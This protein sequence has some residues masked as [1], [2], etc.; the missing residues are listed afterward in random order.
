M[1]GSLVRADALEVGYGLPVCPPMTFTLDAGQ[2]LAV[3]GA[4]GTGKSTLLRTVVGLLEPHAGSLTVLG[5]VPDERSASF[6][7]DVAAD[8][9]EDAFFPS[10]TAREHLLLVA[11]GHGVDD[12]GGLA[13]EL[14]DE[15]GLTDRAAAVPSAL[16]SGQRRRLV[17]ASVLARPRAMLVL[18]EP[19]QRLDAGMRRAL[20][21]RIV[22]EREDG[23]AALLA[24]HDPDVVRGAATAVLLIGDEAVGLVGPDEGADAIERL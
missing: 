24:T 20:T 13:D 7:A 22:E 11:N 9:G 5:A 1:S 18:D 21:A 14:L 23:G 2:V 16:S 15:L 6:R 4:N 17:I 10:L 8:L 19:E 3:V 12:P